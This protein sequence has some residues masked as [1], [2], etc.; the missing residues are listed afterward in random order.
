MGKKKP[1][2]FCFDETEEAWVL[3][4]DEIF[5]E[6]LVSVD[7]LEDGEEQEVLFKRVDMTDEEVENIQE[8]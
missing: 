4:P 5:L 8:G 7:L 3:A 6:N 1:R 2:L